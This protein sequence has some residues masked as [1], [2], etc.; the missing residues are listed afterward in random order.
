MAEPRDRAHDQVEA[1]HVVDGSV[2]D[3]HEVPA[4]PLHRGIPPRVEPLIIEGVEDDP[5]L[6]FARSA[7]R[8]PL[9]H[10]LSAGDGRVGES[11]AHLLAE[12]ERADQRVLR[13][14][15]VL[16]REEFGHAFVEVQ[17]D[18]SAEQPWHER[19][20]DQAVRQRVHLDHVVALP[21]VQPRG[22]QRG[23]DEEGAVLEDVAD[24]PATLTLDRQAVHGEAAAPFMPWLVAPALAD[25]VDLMTRG[26]ERL[27]LA[28]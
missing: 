15:L 2:E 19:R 17:K 28:R 6:L 4:I 12:T 24:L 27:D 14:Q 25:E 11:N 8:E 21:Q 7:L 20:E 23:E 1:V 13:W 5:D 18:A 22:A 26:D 10:L 16:Q 3:E 9:A